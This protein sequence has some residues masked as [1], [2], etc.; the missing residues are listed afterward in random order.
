MRNSCKAIVL[1]ILFTCNIF[2]GTFSDEFFEIT[3]TQ[4][5]KEEFVKTLLP[6]I[7]EANVNVLKERE[8]VLGFFEKTQKSGLKKA[9]KDELL[10]ITN[11]AKKYNIESIEDRKLFE[12]RVDAV[13]VSL[14]LTQAALESGWGTSRFT[15]EANNIFGQWTWSTNENAG[16]VPENREDG[17]THKIRIFKSLQESVNAYILNLNRHDAYKKFRDERAKHGDGFNGVAAAETM[18]NYSE[19]R[20]E[21]VTLLKRVINGNKFLKY[22]EVETVAEASTGGIKGLLVSWLQLGRK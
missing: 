17:K 14:A 21:Y 12:S 4:E 1:F 5:R 2:A 3:D 13:P 18:L 11:I 7:E 16:I 6:L 22:D 10:K 15:K 8:F 20:E 19:I 9:N